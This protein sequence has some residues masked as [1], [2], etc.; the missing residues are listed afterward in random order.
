MPRAN[1]DRVHSIDATLRGGDSRGG[2]VIYNATESPRDGNMPP[3]RGLLTSRR[4]V[5]EWRAGDSD[6][7]DDETA[8][9]AAHPSSVR[10]LKQGPAVP[11][12]GGGAAGP[13]V[14]T[15]SSLRAPAI[16]V[17]S[18]GAHR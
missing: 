13:T 14:R 2:F 17:G 9:S 5:P 16:A 11:S 18:P 3:R 12:V 10:W 15:N 1:L 4:V 8:S 7:A 6:K